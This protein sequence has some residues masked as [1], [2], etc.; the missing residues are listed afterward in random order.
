MKISKRRI[1]KA[2]ILDVTGRIDLQT[3]P[4]FRKILLETLRVEPQVMVNLQQVAYLDSSGIATLVEGYQESNNL[5][6]RILF[7]G[8]APMVRSVLDLT[9]LTKVFE[10]Y[11]TEEQAQQAALRI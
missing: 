5:R 7:Y 1:E 9:H 2:T 8:L 10:I 6:K 11:E 3:S 4:E